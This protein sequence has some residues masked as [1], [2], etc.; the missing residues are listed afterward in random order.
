MTIHYPIITQRPNDR[1][2][3]GCF[4]LIGGLEKPGQNPVEALT[5][6]I[7]QQDQDLRRRQ[8]PFELERDDQQIDM[9]VS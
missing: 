3:S 1:A 7:A 8:S 2:A 4:S 6:M 9:D 5:E